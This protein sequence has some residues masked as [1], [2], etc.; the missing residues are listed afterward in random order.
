[1]KKKRGMKRILSVLLSLVMVLGLMPV[2]AYADDTYP[3]YAAFSHIPLSSCGTYPI[4]S[5]K[6]VEGGAEY[7]LTFATKS[8][9]S[10][11]K[12]GEGSDGTWQTYEA[13]AYNGWEF[14]RWVVCYDG[15]F[16]WGDTPA[17]DGKYYFSKVGF[18]STKLDVYQPKLQINKD[19]DA[20]YDYYIYAVFRP[21]VSFEIDNGMGNLV[22]TDTYS[23]VD[24]VNGGTS[25]R[26]SV[27]YGNN[28]IKITATFNTP[29][30]Y[31]EKKIYVNGEDKTSELMTEG[32][33]KDPLFQNITAPINVRITTVIETKQVSFDANGGSGTMTAQ[34]F[35]YGD[36]QQLTANS[37]TREGYYFTGWNTEQN[38]TID[39][40]G[41]SYTDKQY[42]IFYEPEANKEGITLYAQWEVLK[43]ITDYSAPTAKTG[44]VYDG[45]AQALVSAGTV[46]NGGTMKYSLDKETWST[47]IPTAIN[48]GDYTV[49]YKIEGDLGYYDVE[50]QSIS[51]SIDKATAK[52]TDGETV[53]ATGT[54]GNKLNEL[55]VD[56]LQAM[57]N[58][59][60]VV[61]TWKLNGTEVL[62]AGT[63]E[64]YACTATFTANNFNDLTVEEVTADI[65]ISQA[66]DFVD[67]DFPQASKI[68]YGD[69]LSKS[70][71][72]GG[73]TE[74]GSFAWADNTIVPKSVNDDKH[75]VVFTPN[76]KTLQ[77]FDYD[78][79]ENPVTDTVTVT[80]NKATPTGQPAYTPIRTEG[81]T[82]ADAA[83]KANGG[84][85]SVEGTVKWQ[86]AN[87][88][89]VEQGVAYT[90]VFT[91]A[92]T[93]NYETL[94]G[95][96][97]P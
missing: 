71:L 14:N 58:G 48:A 83:L 19:P 32:S 77:N 45:S 97:I 1:M 36:K 84:T 22:V 59:N 52:A 90:W 80:I 66:E 79:T 65:E 75:T 13:G 15:V 67:I 27:R 49:W 41:E 42:I 55:T 43:D 73:S 11:E 44:L 24:I 96:L 54:Y 4:Q 53:T 30:Y 5:D 70:K 64:D 40:S 89:A 86:D 23:G 92:D 94:T 56:G 78:F 63:Y 10:I 6:L 18:P 47:V 74:Y 7:V 34:I 28:T 8:A 61:G 17:F 39:N 69:A 72:S 25:G 46:E 37:F 29:Y 9:G 31:F 85:F 26:N 76:E 81:K 2:T 95:T 51:V 35:N 57:F 62:D 68:T 93:T 3:G 87:T 21:V 12:T 33:F 82:L 38:P 50:P 16:A 91:P 20:R 60:P 88:T